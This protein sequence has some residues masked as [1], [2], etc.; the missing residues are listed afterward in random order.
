MSDTQREWSIV[1]EVEARRYEHYTVTA[2]S[3]EEALH[4]YHTTHPEAVLTEEVDSDEISV[5]VIA[6]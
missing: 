1:V 4:V 2:A 5:E 3:E 6:E